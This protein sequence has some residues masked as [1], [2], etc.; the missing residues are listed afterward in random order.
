ML[1][2]LHKSSSH[3]QIETEKVIFHK[4][5]ELLKVKLDK[6]K[7]IYLNENTNT[8]IQPDFY[9]EEHCIVGEIFAHIGKPKKSQDNKIANDVL[10]MILLDKV[11][12]KKHRK[13]IVV[14]DTFELKKLQGNSF[15]AES[16]RQ[17]SVELICV[18]IDDNTRSK[19]LE[20]QKLQKMTNVSNS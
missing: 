9:S 2:I 5:E 13:I 10:K 7:R 17:F 14:C 1:D 18:D 3:V 15:L 12:N 4:I 20:A 6:N 11:K 19:V 16:I 8:Y